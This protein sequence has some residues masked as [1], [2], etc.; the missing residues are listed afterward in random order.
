MQKRLGDDFVMMLSEH[1]RVYR[2]KFQLFIFLILSLLFCLINFSQ[3][4]Y[5][6]CSPNWNCTAYI[7]TSQD[8]RVCNAVNDLNNCNITYL[9]NYSEF[10]NETCSC[11]AK[12]SPVIT[13]LAN[14]SLV[15]TELANYSVFENQTVSFN[16]SATDSDNDTITY[17][18]ANTSIA[19]TPQG[20]FLNSSVGEFFWQPLFNQS[21]IYP[22][23]FTATDSCG[24]SDSK[25]VFIEVNET[26]NHPPQLMQ[27]GNKI[28]AEGST[29]TFILNA[30]DLD[31]DTLNFSY[32]NLPAGAVFN[33]A[34]RTFSWAPNYTQAGTYPNVHFEANDNKGGIV[35]EN[36]TITVT[37]VNAAP[38]LQSIGNKQID[39]G[40]LLEFTISATDA[41]NDALNYS[42]SNM[43]AGASFNNLTRRFSW[44]PNDTQAGSYM[45]TFSVSDGNLLDSETISI[46][47]ANKC[48]PSWS[49][50]AWSSCVNGVRDRDCTDANNCGT[51]EGLPL[52][53]ERCPMVSY[54]QTQ[55]T[56]KITLTYENCT[57]DWVCTEWS[58]CNESGFMSRECADKRM[59]GTNNT[60]LVTVQNCEYI[61]ESLSENELAENNSKEASAV[62]QKRGIFS[63]LTTGLATAIDFF[64]NAPAITGAAIG[65]AG[66]KPGE[67]SKKEESSAA[68]ESGTKSGFITMAGNSVAQ[69]KNLVLKISNSA[70]SNPSKVII[71][72][73]LIPAL[74]FFFYKSLSHFFRKRKEKYWYMMK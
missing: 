11:T 42:A 70:K 35:S 41:D 64:R 3:I 63:F 2:K 51:A 14:H 4:S 21:G 67:E 24:L 52:E 26:G 55:A 58:S 18:I 57:E 36:I 74:C 25:I 49:C 46:T 54:T 59:C 71:P 15:I 53:A 7:C 69:I 16:V 5:A 61:P 65:V 22:L 68:K 47:I 40:S 20:A 72:I 56:A 73:V 32:S 39:E 13:E 60:K 30:T 9:G 38:V 17:S 34:T 48:T 44:T 33:Q 12:H 8:L 50:T 37:N 62:A 10:S 29:L 27:I 6:E 19:N 66:E 28:V 23:N 1:G 43:P 31:V 45:A